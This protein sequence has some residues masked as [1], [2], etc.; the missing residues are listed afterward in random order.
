MQRVIELC[1]GFLLLTSLLVICWQLPE[2]EI[3]QTAFFCSKTQLC[4][5]KWIVKSNIIKIIFTRLLL[6]LFYDSRQM[7]NL[8]ESIFRWVS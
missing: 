1:I 2:R 7:G 6:V 8:Q 5:M 4:T 3:F